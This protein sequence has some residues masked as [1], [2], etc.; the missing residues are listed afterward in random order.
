MGLTDKIQT[1]LD[2]RQRELC[3][4]IVTEVLRWIV[5]IVPTFLCVW[6]YAEIT[7]YTVFISSMHVKDQFWLVTSLIIFG[8]SLLVYLPLK[9]FYIRFW[10]IRGISARDR[11]GVYVF[12]S[13]I[14]IF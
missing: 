4:L 10:Y 3:I 12:Y 1:K 13:N 14:I 11:F 8:V 7:G 9:V 6:R 2:E 5:V